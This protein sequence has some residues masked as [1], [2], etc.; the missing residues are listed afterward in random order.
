MGGGFGIHRRH[1]AESALGLAVPPHA[2][3]ARSN[4][5]VGKKHHKNVKFARKK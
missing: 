5:G 1:K 3:G 2:G 4:P